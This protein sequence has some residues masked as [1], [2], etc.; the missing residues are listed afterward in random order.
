MFQFYSLLDVRR[1]CGAECECC[2]LPFETVTQKDKLGNELHP[3]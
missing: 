2:E 1:P 3:L